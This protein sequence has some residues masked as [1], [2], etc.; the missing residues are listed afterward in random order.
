MG[1]VTDYQYIRKH[2]IKLGKEDKVRER[3][4]ELQKELREPGCIV[5]YHDAYEMAYNEIVID[6]NSF[7]F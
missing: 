1:E 4:I 2:T 6:G 7:S 5:P 3:A